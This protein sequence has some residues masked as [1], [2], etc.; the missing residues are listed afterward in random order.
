MLQT[1]EASQMLI[2]FKVNLNRTTDKNV[3]VMIIDTWKMIFKAV[4]LNIIKKR[5]M[6]NIRIHTIKEKLDFIYFFPETV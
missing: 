6:L 5:I 3:Q 4:L 1:I 2:F